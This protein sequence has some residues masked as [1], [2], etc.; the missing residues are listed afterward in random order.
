MLRRLYDWAM[1]MAVSRQARRW[2]V[3]AS[4]SRRLRSQP[5][6]L[7][8]REGQADLLERGLD[9][10]LI[11]SSVRREGLIDEPEESRG[12]CSGA[13]SGAGI[14]STRVPSQADNVL[15]FRRLSGLQ[16]T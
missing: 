1:R 9:P 16:W 4:S 3:G 2:L 8:G 14:G 5:R 6:S 11:A 13:C 10:L 7:G 12:A 15:G